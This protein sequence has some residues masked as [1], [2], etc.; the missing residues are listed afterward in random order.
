MYTSN[1]LVNIHILRFSSLLIVQQIMQ[2]KILLNPIIVKLCSEYLFIKELLFPMIL[3][4]KQ[5]KQ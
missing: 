3:A 2:S 4:F 5:N 1:D